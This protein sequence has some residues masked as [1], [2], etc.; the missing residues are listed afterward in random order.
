MNVQ[1]EEVRSNVANE[2]T[3]A[4][5]EGSTSAYR[6]G[7]R[8]HEAMA[9]AA[10]TAIVLFLVLRYPISASAWLANLPLQVVLLA[11]GVPLLYELGL[12]A[13]GREFG[14]D[15]L[16][17]ISITAS[18]IL[19]Q[20]FAGTVIALMFAGG[21]ALEAMAARRASAVLLALARR[22]PQVAHR[23]GSG[24]VKDIGLDQVRVGDVLAVYPHEICPVDGVFLG[25]HGAMDESYLTGEP[26][27]MSKA[28]GA[29][30]LSGAINGDAALTIRST[31]LPA[32][33][34]YARIMRVMEKAQQSRPR[35]RRLGDR[36]G[37]YYTPV[38]LAVAF[39]AWFLSGQSLRFL[40]VLVIATPCPLLLGIPVSIL[41]AISLAARRGIVI[42]D[43]SVLELAD[44]C[45]TMIFDKTGTLT[46][47]R[48]QLAEQHVAP[49]FDS[50]YILELM[51]SL[52][53]YSKHPLA[54]P[55]V[56][57]ATAAGLM[58]REVN[59]ISE[60]PGAGLRGTVDHSTVWITSRTQF[61]AGVKRVD[62]LP[63]IREGLEC[64]IAIN[65]VY[66]ATYCFRDEPR[67]ES[68]SFITHLLPHHSV[69]R[70][71]LVSG[72]RESETRAIAE[73]VGVSRVFAARSPEEKVAL[74]REETS[75]AKTL[76]VGDGINDAPALLTASVGV[77]LGR[78][79]E[80][81][82]ESAGAVILDASLSKVDELLHIGRRMRMIALQSAFGGMA[83]SV[84]GMILAAVGYL[85]PVA[86]ALTQEAIDF[87]AVVNALRTAR[88][89][90][91][92]TDF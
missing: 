64:V 76:F 43:P 88:A 57:A 36:L 2:A 72:D 30:V 18:V 66:A 51:A 80:I 83:L 92:L 3:A 32:D 45:R 15:L 68:K 8:K 21:N 84:L 44:T 1:T 29:V 19:G 47:G 52:E 82:A 50:R 49:E 61:L 69:Q 59:E 74:V 78:D 17:G 53:Q 77:A 81:A 35:L 89:P 73:R 91:S 63:A 70:V 10:L 86:G 6:A 39:A 56:S 71:L 26:Y 34:R 48:P 20:Y 14:S 58:L 54:I 90:R 87:L 7:S 40:A 27:R 24:G 9:A 65:G 60:P 62:G 46:Y 4:P 33:S 16:A 75:R 37:A 5:A 67:S 11:V 23:E 31:R 28:P 85:P 22:M 38:T 12:R 79:N 13:M 25:G 41:G 55:I 42:R